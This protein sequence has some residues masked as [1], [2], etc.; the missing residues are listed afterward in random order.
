MQIAIQFIPSY[1]R[2]VFVV[3]ND[4]GAQTYHEGDID[5]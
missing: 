5:G 3:D 4:G 1:Y 2:P